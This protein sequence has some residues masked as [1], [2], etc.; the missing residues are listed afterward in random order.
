MTSEK[1]QL[2]VVASTF[3]TDP[4]EAARLSRA[5]G[6]T[7]LQFDAVS[8]AIDLT[9]L[10]QTGRREFRH[11]LSS[12]DQR[13]IG[14]RVDVGPKGFGLSAD[15]D[16]LLARFDKVMDAAKGLSAPLVCIETGPLPEP[17]AAP[18]PKPRIDPSEAGIIIIPTPSA[19]EPAQDTR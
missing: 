13:L 7:G 16:R 18:K 11:V 12:N 14:L 15:I 1:F 6:F 9:E 3:A 19:P 2:G 10:S 17:A 5:N 8:A 4:R